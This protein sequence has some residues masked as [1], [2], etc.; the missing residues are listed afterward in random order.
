MIQTM[1]SGEDQLIYGNATVFTAYG[2][3]VLL[4]VR[5]YTPYPAA[6]ASQG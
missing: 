6:A 4:W 5:T 3:A 1:H 2:D